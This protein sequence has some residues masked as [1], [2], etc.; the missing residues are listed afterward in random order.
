MADEDPF[1][2]D[3]GY[4]G[5]G[6]FNPADSGGDFFQQ[7]PA[8][9]EPAFNPVDNSDPFN[10]MSDRAGSADGTFASAMP[11]GSSADDSGFAFAP[12]PAAGG[13]DDEAGFPEPA[14]SHGSSKAAAA[15]GKEGMFDGPPRPGTP[16]AVQQWRVEFAGKIEER[17]K[18]ES[19][20]RAANKQSSAAALTRMNQKFVE[21][22]AK[23][24]AE[25]D[26]E[27]KKV[28]QKRDATEAKLSKKGQPP[29]W[30]V[31]EELCDLS[32]NYV[33]GQRDTSRM[34]GVLLKLKTF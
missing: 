27:D 34:R 9:D 24:K 8:Q 11:G 18:H 1:G 14:R 28:K 2:A 17:K 32:G 29:N 23:N 22:C 25:N 19:A 6:S 26:V 31:V 21:K 12:E 3:G 5:D 30:N 7:Y 13:Y 10:N 20:T 33:E 16:P 4:P 15:G